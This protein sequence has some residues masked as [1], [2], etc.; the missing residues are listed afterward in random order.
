MH[1]AQQRAQQ[2]S[3][4]R[5]FTGDGLQDGYVDAFRH[6]RFWPIDI[7]VDE[8]PNRGHLSIRL[9][10][11]IPEAILKASA[12]WRME[13]DGH[14]VPVSVSRRGRILHFEGR[15]A[16]VL[17]ASLTGRRGLAILSDGKTVATTGLG[18]L[19]AVIG[20]FTT[21]RLSVL[22]KRAEAQASEEPLLRPQ[23]G[24]EPPDI[25]SAE[26]L[27]PLRKYNLCSSQSD[28]HPISYHR[29]DAD[30]TLAVIQT[31][32]GG[33]NRLSRLVL[34]NRTGAA[35]P[36]P[37]A[38]H[39]L[40]EV[41]LGAEY[42]PNVQWDRETETVKVFSKGS[43]VADCGSKLR[44]AWDGLEFQSVEYAS[45]PKCGLGGFDFIVTYRRLM[46]S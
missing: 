19:K 4:R 16:S 17:L 11:R 41:G 35:R 30:T 38:P 20:H 24:Q 26:A 29:L 15:E 34:V 43:I 13:V 44:F 10:T 8:A 23:S 14:P 46:A 9:E 7:V 37:M 32:C 12:H 36:A 39:P 28:I 45:M 31:D 18:G 5:S 40:Q 33:F 1:M 3:A 2:V 42:L 25:L 6:D 22:R 27:S 21:T